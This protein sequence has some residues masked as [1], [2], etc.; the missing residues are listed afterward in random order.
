MK[1][2][3]GQARRRHYEFAHRA[4]PEI[5]LSPQTD[6]TWWL[7]DPERFEGALRATWKDVGARHLE[8]EG[9]SDVGLSVEH[10]Y[11]NGVDG[12]LVTLPTALNPNEAIFVLVVPLVPP[13]E[14]RF[15]TLEAGR[16][17]NGQAYTA[18]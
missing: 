14:R 15:F 17:M 13:M 3:H 2:E 11:V 7:S 5:M 9:V 4:L 12:L 8:A 6:L 1:T 18:L 10:R 16:V